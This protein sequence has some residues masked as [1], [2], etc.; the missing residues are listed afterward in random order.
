MLQM[1]W[2]AKCLPFLDWIECR[3]A[4]GKLVMFRI[5]FRVQVIVTNNIYNF[6]ERDIC[7]SCKT[8][9]ANLKCVPVEGGNDR[10]E[11]DQG[12]ELKGKYCEKT[13]GK[14]H[15]VVVSLLPI[16]WKLHWEIHFP[17]NINL[18]QDTTWH[19]IYGAI[20]RYFPLLSVTLSGCVTMAREGLIEKKACN[21]LFRGAHYREE[22]SSRI[23][24]EYR[25][26]NLHSSLESSTPAETKKR[27][28]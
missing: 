4:L 17:S 6:S 2:W 21:H 13:C 22:T 18:Q 16:L 7:H 24:R 3:M 19:T 11:C 26:S 14:L 28:N 15:M 25:L 9:R 5:I 1:T 12:Y 20:F 8:C 27:V 10:H 23:K